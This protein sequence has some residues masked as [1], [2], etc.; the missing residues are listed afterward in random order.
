[1]VNAISFYRLMAAPVLL[2]LM[3][4]GNIDI[5]KWLLAISFFTDSIDGFLARRFK[6]RSRLG[7]RI[8]SIADDL[9][10]L[11]AI[12]G[13]FLLKPGFVRQE[14]FLI[15]VL[16][17]LFQ[18]QTIIAFIRYGR[19]SSFHTILAK[20]AALF[21]GTFLILLYFLP[22]WPTFLF[23]IAAAFTILDLVEEIILVILLPKWKTDVKG[24]FWLKKRFRSVDMIRNRIH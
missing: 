1:M 8:D 9:T 19:M 12:I 13:M 7:S 10:V 18:V 6:V 17:V 3:L 2:I 24:L 21:Q 14:L 22:V 16:L 15:T 5:F 20:V 23:H 4:N 11:V